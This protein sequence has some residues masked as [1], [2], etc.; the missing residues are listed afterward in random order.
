MI[1]DFDA[2]VGEPPQQLF[3]T[4]AADADCEGNTPVSR[5]QFLGVLTLRIR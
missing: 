2:I 4:T 5:P 1:N 3:R